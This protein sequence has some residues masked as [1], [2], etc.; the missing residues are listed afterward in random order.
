[1]LNPYIFLNVNENFSLTA[2][3]VVKKH[4]RKMKNHNAQLLC[5]HTSDSLNWS[6]ASFPY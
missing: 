5:I 4:K 6:I 2:T 1:M 3:E